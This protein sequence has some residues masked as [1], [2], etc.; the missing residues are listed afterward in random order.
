MHVRTLSWLRVDD[1]LY[2]LE[3]C[4]GNWKI[5][6]ELQK[7]GGGDKNYLDRVHDWEVLMCN[8]NW[9]NVVKIE[10]YD[11]NWKRNGEEGKKLLRQGPWLRGADVRAPSRALWWPP[12]GT[13]LIHKSA[14]T[15]SYV[16][17]DSFICVTWLIHMCDMAHSYVW[18][19]SSIGITWRI[20][21]FHSFICVTRLHIPFASHV[22]VRGLIR[23]SLAKGEGNFVLLQLAF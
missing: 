22:C 16:W 5:R 15:H 10:R 11:E 17:R 9:E 12:G 2:K 6:W 3:K 4:G 18:H 20:R 8:T 14:M 1:V 23:V 7:N 19:N 13:W 21:M